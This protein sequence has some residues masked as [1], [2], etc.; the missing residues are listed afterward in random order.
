[1]EPNEL[2]LHLLSP[3]NVNT[4][5]LEQF[6][7]LWDRVRAADYAFEDSLRGSKEWFAASMLEAGTFNFELPQVAF[8]QLTNAA[9]NLNAHIHFITYG[10]TPAG[11][12][13]DAARELLTFAFEQVGVHRVQAWVPSFNHK[14][15]R[16]AGMLHMRFEGQLRRAFLYETQW[17]DL[18]MYGIISDEWHH[19]E[20]GKPNGGGKHYYN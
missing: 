18:V 11:P 4:C 10:H 7:Q 8:V 14:A 19:Q 17:Y 15:I 16:M 5:S 1:V 12:L 3:I 2:G 20:R 13:L 6:E 9:P